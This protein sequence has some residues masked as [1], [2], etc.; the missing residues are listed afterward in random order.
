MR[1]AA[2]DK[3]GSGQRNR[4]VFV[5][6]CALLCVFL[7][8]CIPDLG[9]E[10]PPPGTDASVPDDTGPRG[11]GGEAG[12]DAGARTDATVT[13][14][15]DAGDILAWGERIF[16]IEAGGTGCDYCHGATAGGGMGI[17][18]NIRGEQFPAIRFALRDVTDMDFRMTDAE[19]E[20][21]VVYLRYLK[22]TY[23]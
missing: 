6:R 17:G 14:P 3:T 21:V 1:G 22:D 15:T 10:L 20:A 9:A 8:A 12:L 11:D 18:P 5:C 19:I 4:T 13:P 7:A 2:G 16:L 23:G